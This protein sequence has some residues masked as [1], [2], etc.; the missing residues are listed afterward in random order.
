MDEGFGGLRLVCDS[1]M[2]SFLMDA[3]TLAQVSGDVAHYLHDGVSR[4]LAVI[5]VRL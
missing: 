3:L 2:I 4:E 1:F 5:I